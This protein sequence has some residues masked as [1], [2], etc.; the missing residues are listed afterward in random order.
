MIELKTLYEQD[1]T[2]WAL[3]NLELLKAGRFTELDIANLEEESF[4][5][6]LVGACARYLP[7]SAWIQANFLQNMVGVL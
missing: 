2:A 7:V 6:C 4:C 5:S 1:F 3:Q